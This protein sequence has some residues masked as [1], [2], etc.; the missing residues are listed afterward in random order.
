MQNPESFPQSDPSSFDPNVSQPL[1]HPDFTQFEQQVDESQNHVAQCSELLYDYWKSLQLTLHGL[2]FRFPKDFIAETQFFITNPSTVVLEILCAII[3]AIIM[4]PESISFA[5]MVDLGPLVGLHSTCIIMLASAI[6]GCRPAMICGAAGS[7]CLALQALGGNNGLLQELTY[8][9]RADAIFMTMFFCGIFQ[10]ALSW[11]KFSQYLKLLPQSAIIGFINC[12]ALAVAWSQKHVIETCEPTNGETYLFGQCPSEYI[13]WFHFDQPE[14]WYTLILF[15]IGIIVIIAWSF[16]PKIS[17]VIPSSLIVMIIGCFIEHVIYR[18][19]FHIQTRTLKE[20]A[21]L[22]G[23]LPKFHFPTIVSTS[24]THTWSYILSYAASAAIIGTLE[25]LLTVIAMN[26]QLDILTSDADLNKETFAQGVGN[27][28]CSMT[29]SIGG[30]ALI[31]ESNLNILNGARHRLSA[32]I[33]SLFLFATILWISP[34]INYIPVASLGSVIICVAFQTFYW[35][36]FTILHKMRR[37]DAF[38]IIVVMVL[39]WFTNLAIAMGIGFIIAAFSLVLDNSNT[40]QIIPASEPQYLSVIVDKSTAYVQ[41]DDDTINHDDVNSINIQTSPYANQYEPQHSNLNNPGQTDDPNIISVQ[42]PQPITTQGEIELHP[43]QTVFLS[44][45]HLVSSPRSLESPRAPSPST[46]AALDRQFCLHF[47]PDSS[48]QTQNLHNSRNTPHNQLEL[49]RLSSN[50]DTEIHSKSQHQTP[51]NHH[52]T[53]ELDNTASITQVTVSKLVQTYYLSGLL[54]FGNVSTFQDRFFP[55]NDPTWV[56]LDFS[57]CVLND[58]SAISAL[59]ILLQR[60]D[61][62]GVRIKL[63]SLSDARSRRHLMQFAPLREKLC[64]IDYQTYILLTSDE[65]RQR[66]EIVASNR[67]TGHEENN[68]S[69]TFL[70]RILSFGLSRPH[71]DRES[72]AAIADDNDNDDDEDY[73]NNN[74]QT[75]NSVTTSSRYRAMNGAQDE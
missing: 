3:I 10:V 28:I 42:Y 34:V 15:F 33:S 47:L 59:H 24:E 36:T 22:H 64:R 19:I 23:A 69:Q 70:S 12:L 9:Q 63:T 6:L 16:L 7:V 8:D 39:G 18:Q 75:T 72:A 37:H 30:C 49:Q 40:L 54:F 58:Y 74:A 56:C 35:N 62:A 65:Q 2:I 50:S 66:Q 57:R 45:S 60:Y 11:L 14:L 25:T 71:R 48:L 55:S 43:H 4:V 53:V 46:M 17:K 21:P 31:G 73:T 44:P 67:L 20:T 32:I 29:G 51:S 61:D 52:E 26:N 68:D 13:H 27:I 41:D 5:Y 1:Y 38:I